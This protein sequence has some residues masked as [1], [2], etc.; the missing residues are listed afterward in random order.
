MFRVGFSL[1]VV[2][3]LFSGALSRR[4]ELLSR[5]EVEAKGITW[6]GNSSNS[7]ENLLTVQTYPSDFTWCNKD[8]VNYCTM[9]RNQHIPQYCGSCWAHGT[10]SALADRIKIARGA[11]G[12]D[13]NLSIQ[14]L[15]NCGTAGSC[16]GGSIDGPYQWI[17]QISNQT[18]TGISYETAQP[19]LACSSDSN[20]GF[21]PKV[22]TTCK[23]INVA[24]TCGSFSQEGG[25][26]VGLSSYPN[27]TVADYGSISGQDAMM[28]EIFNRGPIASGVD[29][30]K[31][32]NYESGILNLP[33]GGIDHVISVVGWSTDPQQGF[34]WIVRNS[35]GEFWGEMGYFRL[36]KG[37]LNIEDQCSWAVPGP[38]T[39]NELNNQ[40]H[41]HEGGDNCQTKKDLEKLTDAFLSL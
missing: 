8:G 31:H 17:A 14:H 36:A 33:G 15:M 39:A 18:G 27:A 5:E 20:E 12:V 2:L 28:K 23:P 25:P 29:A 22:D 30:S 40:I 6:R 16:N 7:H 9:S 37:A 19:Y 21:C 35:W 41:C 11:K 24:R 13:I 32:L 10:M 34:H 38:F 1:L 4:N 26:C 3:S